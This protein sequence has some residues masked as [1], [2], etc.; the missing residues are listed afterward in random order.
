MGGNTLLG[1]E[2]GFPMAM[3]GISSGDLSNAYR[4]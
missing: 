4:V 1:G 3:S 2:Q